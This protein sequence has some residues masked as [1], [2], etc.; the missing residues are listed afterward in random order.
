[1]SFYEY[2]IEKAKENLRVNI[3]EKADEPWLD[4]VCDCRAGK[5][6]QDNY[7]IV[8]E[9]VADDDVY[10]TLILYE[11][12]LL[13][14]EETLKWLKIKKLFNQILFHTDHAL[15]CCKYVKAEKVM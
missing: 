7:D 4:Y 15:N 14:K 3:F 8:M 1:M 11:R 9:S 13:D 5:D 12:G 6:G 10:A 2:D